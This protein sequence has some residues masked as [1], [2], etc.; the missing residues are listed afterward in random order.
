MDVKLLDFNGSKVLTY[1]QI[2]ATAKTSVE[3]L[4]VSFTRHKKDFVKGKDFIVLSGHDLRSFFDEHDNEIPEKIETTRKLYLWTRSGSRKLLSFL[5]STK[6]QQAEEAVKVEAE[7]KKNEVA[8][9]DVVKVD[10]SNIQFLE[11][12]GERVVTTKELA[13]ML[14]TKP[15]NISSNFKNN[16]HEYVEGTDYY[17]LC[18]NKLKSF[19]MTLG[20]SSLLSNNISKLYLWTSEGARLCAK[21]IHTKE[22]A[23]VWYRAQE[24]FDNKVGSGVNL[25]NGVKFA[26]IEYNGRPVL[27][28]EDLARAYDCSAENIL[29]NYRRNKNKFQIGIDFYRLTGEEFKKF[30]EV[31]PNCPNL[32]NRNSLYL[33]TELGASIHCKSINTD[34]AWQWFKVLHEFY[35]AVK[36]GNYRVQDVSKVDD[37]SND[38]EEWKEIA[39]KAVDGLVEMNRELYKLS[40]K[41]EKLIQDLLELAKASAPYINK[42]RNQDLD[43]MDVINQPI[44][45]EATNN[46][47]QNKNIPKAS[48][49]DAHLNRHTAFNLTNSEKISEIHRLVGKY[50]SSNTSPITPKMKYSEGYRMLYDSV[51][52]KLGRDIR[53]ERFRIPGAKG[54]S[55]LICYVEHLGL[56]DVILE[57]AQELFE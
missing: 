10:S 43:V 21:S 36:E 17:C 13:K 3:T 39:F 4:R 23:D 25:I 1:G 20:G 8:A 57:T 11:Y 53:K 50:V 26:K 32:N 24:I 34:R 41:R 7:S 35:F 44:P 5:R 45:T 2:A 33:W 48:A 38:A 14:R 15:E 29:R 51:I 49:D 40:D 18:G 52:S 22:A 56:G 47:T 54:K 31:R 16:L 19:K 55:Q 37:K 6:K 9:A 28:T 30:K 46:L 27:M 42:D 12:N